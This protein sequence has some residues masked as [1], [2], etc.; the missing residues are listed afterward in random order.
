MYV[1][2]LDPRIKKI[3]SK[4][5]IILLKC[6]QN[7]ILIIHFIRS[8]CTH[9]LSFSITEKLNVD[10]A[11]TLGDLEETHSSILNNIENAMFNSTFKI[12]LCI[13]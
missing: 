5:K 4:Q 11:N 13:F 9:T 10:T 12:L 1:T 7:V 6:N 8:H 2:T 3:I